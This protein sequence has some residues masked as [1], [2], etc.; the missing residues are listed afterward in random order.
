MAI[1][2]YDPTTNRNA[3]SPADKAARRANLM[4]SQYGRCIWCGCDMQTTDSTRGD[5]C[6]A[7]HLVPW[8]ICR[9]YARRYIVGACLA[10]NNK[11]GDHVSTQ[12]MCDT[13]GYD[14]E[15][16]TAWAAL[17]WK[18]RKANPWEVRPDMHDY[19]KE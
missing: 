7:E 19:G 12:T 13:V 4:A 5:Y 1:T 10:C 2:N 15:E 11:R 8:P 6:T 16:L 18:A 17:T 3:G 9:S 14:L